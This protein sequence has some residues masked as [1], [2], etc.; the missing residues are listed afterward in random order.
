MVR[1]HGRRDDNQTADSALPRTK[2]RTRSHKKRRR[3]FPQRSG[4]LHGCLGLSDRS[5]IVRGD[6]TPVKPFMPE[7]RDWG[8]RIAEILQVAG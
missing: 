1:R 3:A 7:I 6:K 2:E 5:E 8:V 4:R